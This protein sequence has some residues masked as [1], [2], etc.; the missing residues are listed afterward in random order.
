[1]RALG[2][3]DGDILDV[4]VAAATR[5]FFATVLDATGALP[6]AALRDQDPALRD[7]LTV[8]RPI[9]QA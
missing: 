3:A 5:S 7:A 1:L 6:D 2:Y 9:E 4:V 8:G